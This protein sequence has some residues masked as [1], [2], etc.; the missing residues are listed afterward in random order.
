MPG[1]DQTG[2]TGN[3]PK[4]GRGRGRCLNISGSSAGQSGPVYGVGR[5]GIPFGC[6]MGRGAGSRDSINMRSGRRDFQDN[7]SVDVQTIEDELARARATIAELES[8]LRNVK[9]DVND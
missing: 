9:P 6:G 1:F 8:R 5:G 2:P 7:S 3:G 4:T